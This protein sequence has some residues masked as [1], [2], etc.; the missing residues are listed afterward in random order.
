MHD[1]P[2]LGPTYMILTLFIIVTAFPFFWMLITMFKTSQD[3]YR[4]NNNPFIFNQPPT[5]DNIRLL[6][7]GSNYPQFALNSLVIGLAVVGI[8]VVVSVPAAYSLARLAGR[9]GERLGI[10]I[11]LVY[12][13]PPTLLFIPMARVVTLLGLRDSY[14]SLIV[15]YPTFTIP[16]CTWLLM[17]FM[18]TLP[19]D[20]EEQA[21]VDGYSRVGAML[22]VVLPLSL[23]GVLTIAVFSFTLTLNEYIYALAFVSASSQKPISVGVTTELVRGDVFYW[24]ALMAGAVFVAIP[25]AILYNVFLNRFVAGFTLG[26]VKG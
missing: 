3:L 21:M 11:F 9:W 4:P 5:L 22:R 12:L 7:T 19:K 14:W 8:T 1:K 10:A 24:Q 16:F 20:I 26:A 17:G 2:R 18:R 6:L 23:P 13:V 15:V 25:V